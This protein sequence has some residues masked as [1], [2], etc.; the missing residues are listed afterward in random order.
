MRRSKRRALG[1]HFLSNHKVLDRIVEYAQL[2]K[3]DVVLEVGA[4]RGELTRRLAEKAGRIIAVEIDQDLAEALKALA[5][6]YSNIELIIGDVLRVKPAGF[7]KVVSNP[8]YSISS[9]LIE[10]LMDS[11]PELMVLTLQ[12]EFASKLVAC[13]G[14]SKYLYISVISSLLYDSKILEIVPRRFFN[15]PPKVDSV[16]VS[17]KRRADAPELKAS[18]KKLWRALFTRRRQVLRRVLSDMLRED[19]IDEN[20]FRSIPE[21]LLPRR[22]FQLTP[23]ELLSLAEILDPNGKPN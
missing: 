2:S 21:R 15:P 20:T 8:P 19:V 1:Q 10:W 23:S 12:K 9:R 14:S 5:E 13:P 17:M 18:W 11:K 22:I 16:I 7:N 4:G 6:A 3:S